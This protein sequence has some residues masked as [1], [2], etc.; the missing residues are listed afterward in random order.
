MKTAKAKP[1]K[2]TAKQRAV[3]NDDAMAKRFKADPEYGIYY[4]NHVLAEGTQPDIL[5]ALR[6][7]TQAFDGLP[8]TA[9]KAKLN[10]TSVYRS[11]SVNGNPGLDTLLALLKALGLQFSVK[12][13]S[14]REA[15]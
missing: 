15:A 14:S 4:L 2:K 9:A 7:L 12:K 3:S 13:E 6:W 10:P 5:R 1:A 11:L 8:K